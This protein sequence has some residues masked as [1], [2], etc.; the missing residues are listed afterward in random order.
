M[1]RIKRRRPKNYAIVF[2]SVLI[3]ITIGYAAFAQPLAHQLATML[4]DDFPYG[5]WPR[6][7]NNQNSKDTANN[8]NNINKNN[9]NNSLLSV[10]GDNKVSDNNA[11]WDIRFINVKK[12]ASTGDASEIATPTYDRLNG[13]FHVLLPKE[14]DSITYTFTIKNIG[15]LDAKVDSII[16]TLDNDASDVIK[17]KVEGMEVGDTLDAGETKEMKVIA[18]HD[19]QESIGDTKPSKSVSIS[20]LYKQK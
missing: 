10:D 2:A 19:E 17:F 12:T 15:V 11:Q 1:R 18:Y 20:I 7:D 5:I 16:T 8:V 14:G 4:P 13:K 9:T 6:P 3:F